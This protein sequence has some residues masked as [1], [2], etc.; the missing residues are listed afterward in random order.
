[1]D[2]DSSIGALN[3]GDGGSRCRWLGHTPAMVVW[4]LVYP[5]PILENFAKFYRPPQT[6]VAI[7]HC[8]KP[9]QAISEAAE[10]HNVHDDWAVLLPEDKRT[11][12]NFRDQPLAFSLPESLRVFGGK[13]VTI[14]ACR[15]C[16]VNVP[17]FPAAPASP[18]PSL[19]GCNQVLVFGSLSQLS[20]STRTLC[21][22][23]KPLA[24]TVWNT[25]VAEERWKLIDP[26]AEALFSGGRL[27]QM[28]QASTP[29]EL[30]QRMWFSSGP[31]IRWNAARIDAMFQDLKCGSR[32]FSPS[33]SESL[34]GWAPFYSAVTVASEHRIAM[35]TEYLPCG[36]ADGRD[37]WLSPY[38]SHCGADMAS[39]AGGAGSESRQDFR[40]CP[41]CRRVGG[42]V[43][44]QKRR[45]MGWAPYRPLYSLLDREAADKLVETASVQL[46]ANG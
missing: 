36:F 26:L 1:M 42:P 31:V 32:S 38:C 39:V 9:L 15:H 16:P 44:E 24:K 7:Q 3:R 23:P 43:P 29:R 21:N 34:T 17:R 45:I 27:R 46:G 10:L 5:C 25:T 20:E 11:H 12:G 40:H 8:L 18:E 14:D 30:W 37:W 22:A 19:A 6:P 13:E 28:L 35:E 2:H 33:D 4:R 41:V